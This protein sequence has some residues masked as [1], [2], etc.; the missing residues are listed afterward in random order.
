MNTAAPRIALLVAIGGFAA[1]GH[2]QNVDTSEWVCEFC[3]FEAGHSAN[4]EVGASSVS[5]DS[6]YLGNATGYDEKGAFANL[7]GD[8]TYS[9]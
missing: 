4:Y 6:A 1:N 2:A 8:G 3:P 5:D 9:K 7:D